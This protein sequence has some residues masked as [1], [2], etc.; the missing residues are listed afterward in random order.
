M[1]PGFLLPRKLWKIMNR[2]RT[3]H[4]CCGEKMFLWKYIDSPLCDC[5]HASTQTMSHII[6]ECALRRFSGGISEI[7]SATT[8]SIEWLKNLD[9]NLW[10]EKKTKKKKKENRIFQCYLP[11]VLVSIAIV[12]NEFFVIRLHTHKYI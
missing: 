4:G 12:F 2:L 8:E 10:L 1:V 3:G 7:H 6:N 11:V 9:L 5:D